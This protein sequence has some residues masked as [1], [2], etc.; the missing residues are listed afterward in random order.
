MP[1]FEPKPT[2]DWR[3]WLALAWAIWFGAQYVEMV[4][5][6]RAAKAIAIIKALVAAAH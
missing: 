1:R 4:A 6:S 2:K 3:A 5:A